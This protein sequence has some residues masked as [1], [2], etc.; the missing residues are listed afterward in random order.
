MCPLRSTWAAG[1]GMQDHVKIHALPLW[2]LVSNLKTS[3]QQ[4][5]TRHET[6]KIRNFDFQVVRE[7]SEI[8][9]PVMASL[10][11]HSIFGN[12][13]RNWIL[14]NAQLMD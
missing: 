14:W 6:R 7:D 4:T 13:I 12:M 5:W 3:K 1:V 10:H 11:A 2:L 9:I 8:K